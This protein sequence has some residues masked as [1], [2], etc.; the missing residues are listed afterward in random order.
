MT[1]QE[2]TWLDEAVLEY[3]EKTNRPDSVDI[4]NHFKLRA[5]TTLASVSRLQQAGKIARIQVGLRSWYE[6]K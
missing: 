4:V 5:D 3:I 1:N 6:A 2:F